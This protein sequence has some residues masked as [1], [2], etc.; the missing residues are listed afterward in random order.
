[1]KRVGV[2]IVIA[3]ALLGACSSSK[4]SS[5]GPASAA[6]AVSQATLRAGLPEA[7]TPVVGSFVGDETA[8]V[9]GSDGK[10]HVVYELWLTNAKQVL[11][12]ISSLEVLDYDHRA[13][14]L[15]HI[16]GADL[17][18]RQL[19]VRP[20]AAGLEPGLAASLPVEPVLQPNESMLVFIEL[21]FDRRADVPARIVH[22]LVGTGATNPGSKAPQPVDYLLLPWDVSGHTTPV[23]GRP[24]AG[25]GWVAVN[26]CCAVSG[27]HRAS[28]QSVNGIL[29]DSQRFAID[30][31]R[32]GPNGRFFHDD[33]TNPHDWYNYG[34][35][36]LA[37]ADAT[38]VS[39]ADSLP[40][41]PP[42]SLPD[43]TT[44]TLQSVDGNHVVL[45]LGNGVY[46]FYAHLQKGSITVKQGDKV[47]AGQPVGLLG[48]SGNTSA[49]HLHI[50]LMAGP[51]P[52]ASDGIPMSYDHY[53]LTGAVDPAQWA[54][55]TDAIDD[56]WKIVHPDR[57]AQQAT[58]P[59][60]LAVVDFGASSTN[61]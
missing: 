58:M 47:K 1:M 20:R 44:I 30:W 26:G 57:D 10:L 40:D 34:A 6:S 38:V 28:V 42:G 29:V 22:H 16:D 11:A 19:S 51:S 4:S 32:I 46:A 25:D 60:N 14:V 5:S 43:P 21:V 36:V 50:H 59:L 56:V 55:T 49:P 23:V 61:S 9:L 2:V 12:T 15:Q 24:L 3:S 37:V 52:L 54:E 39:V 27:A 7:F 41:Q 35:P 33:P 53:T 8:P 45:D 18:T 13:R 48:N 17:S 31:M